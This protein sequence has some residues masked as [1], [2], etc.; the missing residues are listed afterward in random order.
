[1]EDSQDGKS[2]LHPDASP[3]VDC[4]AGVEEF[5]DIKKTDK[6]SLQYFSLLKTSPE[7]KE[8]E[9]K[10]SLPKAAFIPPEILADPLVFSDWGNLTHR[11]KAYIF[12]S[13]QPNAQNHSPSS[14]SSSVIEQL[15]KNM[16]P[17]F[18]IAH[19]Q[20]QLDA[21]LEKSGLRS[22]SNLSRTAF[23]TTK[24][25]PINEITPNGS[26]SKNKDA[27]KDVKEEEVIYEISIYP[28]GR[29]PEK[30]SQGFKFLGSQPL[31]DFRDAIYCQEDFLSYPSIEKEVENERNVAA[32]Q[33]NHAPAIITFVPKPNQEN[34]ATKKTSSSYFFF[35][36]VFYIDRRS[37][38][39][40]D[41]SIEVCRWNNDPELA[42][43]PPIKDLIKLDMSEHT[44]DQL[45]LRVNQPYLFCHQGS[46]QHI[47]IVHSI[48][49][50]HPSLDDLCSANYPIK[51]FQSSYQMRMHCNTCKNNP[52]EYV[53]TN[54]IHGGTK[55]MFYCKTCHDLFHF[56]KDG[57]PIYP[58]CVYPYLY[59]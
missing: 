21:A 8:I 16:T 10:F 5:L 36:N 11:S 35:E 22:L 31:T 25:E 49:L 52:A 18:S 6:D 33:A 29:P 1:M 37:P 2:K 20:Y 48:R 32:F 38:S 9:S 44:F 14:E 24:K 58:I 34:T 12:D 3:L 39:Y 7:F 56:S 17:S 55:A 30:K 23:S 15:A 42:S 43:D 45:E 4:K 26:S 50:V 28:P 51:T 53:V 41:Y 27:I 13:I 47:V 59:D 46:C 19:R 54:D 40:V 57:K